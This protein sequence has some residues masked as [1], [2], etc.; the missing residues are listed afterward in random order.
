MQGVAENI[1]PSIEYKIARDFLENVP[2][3]LTLANKSL[4]RIRLM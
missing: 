4:P 3:S 1:F 2:F